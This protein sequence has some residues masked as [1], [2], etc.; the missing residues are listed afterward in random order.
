MLWSL[1]LLPVIAGA[2]LL[3]SGIRSRR[4]LGA[5]A[6]AAQL[7]TVLVAAIAI[8]GRWTASLVWNQTLHLEAALTPLSAVVAA[9]VPVI[10][11]PI[12]LYA[13]MHEA[14]AGLPRL[15]ALLLVFVGGMELLV[16]AADFLTLLIGWEVV[17]AISWALISH[18]W[19]E[20]EN[21]PAAAYAFVTTRFGDLGLF[22]AAF[23]TFA[24]SG[25]FAYEALGKLTD[26]ELQLVAA[27]LL[28]SAAAKS[29]QLPF[30]PWLFRAMAGPTSVSALL[31]AAAMVAAGVY[32]L[33]RLEPDL[34]HAAG[35]SQATL[36]VGLVTAIGGGV[37]AL[38]QSHAKKLLAASTSMHYGLMLVAVGA[39]YPVVAILHMVAHAAFKALMFLV[40]GTAGE[41]AGTFALHRMRVGRLLPLAAALSAI[42]ALALAGI[43][44]LGAAWTKEAIVS[45]AGHAGSWLAVAVAVVGGF[46]AAYAARFQ[47]LAYGGHNAPAGTRP[48]L[49]EHAALLYLAVLTLLLGVLWLPTVREMTA[50]VLGRE[51]PG[52]KTWELVI[53][54]ALLGAGLVAGWFV[55][56]R[57]PALGTAGALAQAANWL[58]LPTLIRATVTQPVER[59]AAAAARFDDDVVDAAV[60]ALVPAR[61]ARFGDRIGERVADGIPE[62]AARL[63][64]VSGRD[65]RRLQ[66]GMSHHYYLLLVAGSAVAAAILILGS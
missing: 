16:V 57:F 10:A 50:V 40:A 9:L 48:T 53:S 51:I 63:V 18:R 20:K 8:D 25:S 28:V 56:R 44:P 22:V 19:H 36:A 11:T 62:C 47:I 55:A 39:G 12:V 59:F 30:A 49:A 64:S 32:L 33:A 1:P 52:S 38:L 37:V 29:G 45:A 27:G 31:H 61:L 65:I 46:G 41:A 54:L 5:L 7:L 4:S 6:V 43:P 2:A 14:E 3:A 66:T 15:I 60:R 34:A 24:G 17:G 21:P 42:G 26:G 35:F 13:A 23:T 58:G